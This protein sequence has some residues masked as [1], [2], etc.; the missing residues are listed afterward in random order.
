MSVSK[1]L[2]MSDAP[3]ARTWKLAK[4]IRREIADAELCGIIQ[5]APRQTRRF[6]KVNV[7][8]QSLV[9]R[10]VD[11][12]L[13]FI[14]GCPGRKSSAGTNS[15]IECAEVCPLLSVDDL[16]DSNVLNFITDREPDLVI[17]I[18]DHDIR[19]K[20][21][22]IPQ[23]G[24]LRP[25]QS[26]IQDNASRSTDI[27]VEAFTNESYS[28]V[29]MAQVNLPIQPLDGITGQALK[30]DLISDD[31]TLQCAKHLLK[32]NFA[33]S[34]AAVADWTREIFSPYLKQ[35]GNGQCESHKGTRSPERYRSTLS[36]LLDTM[37]LCSP[38]M[39][40]RNW[41]RRLRRRYPITI[42]THHLVSDR[43]HRMAIRT[44]SFL[45]QV[46]FLQRH[47]R[48]VSLTEAVE[49]LK[50]GRVESPTA[51]ITFDD[52]YADNFVGLRAVAEETGIPVTLFVSTE[53]IEKQKEFQH[54]LENYIHGFLPLTWSQIRHWS[55]GQVEFE[56][57]TRTHFDCS[58]SER[59]KLEYEIVGSRNDLER[60]I[61]MP[62]KFFA[63]PFGQPENMSREAIETAS[64]C[65]D[66]FLSG[67]GGENTCNSEKSNQ[68]L[69]RRNLYANAWEQE[70]D[71]QSVF[72]LADKIKK[73]RHWWSRSYN[74]WPTLRPVL[75]GSA[76]ETVVKQ[77]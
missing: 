1:I 73:L 72:D 29:R 42:L 51:V 3:P 75:A 74:A 18:G 24:W 26:V 68:H 22:Q 46:R 64:R 55:A 44:E 53:Q 5:S 37:L 25:V 27:T 76:A 23:R 52:G 35:L 13:W 65:Y 45:G 30:T 67:F 62:V 70:L 7:S 48:I 56:A 66:Y 34:A 60:E 28:P 69:V 8:F 20:L 54:D 10:L 31:L 17:V 15:A 16:N 49:L 77:N 11:S 57:H 41:I 38:M 9:R 61:G 59:S 4:R 39:V 32:S 43:P 63:F 36:L 14:H 2:V 71:L 6:S 50:S 19:G 33:D 21:L 12:A 58:T 40:G 47:Y